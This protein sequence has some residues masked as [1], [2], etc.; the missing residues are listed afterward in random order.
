MPTY[1]YLCKT[2]G[3]RF[4]EFHSIASEPVQACP[5]CGNAVERLI[6]GG[7]GLIFKGS[8][9]YLTDY[10]KSN[11]STAAKTD[12]EP[13]A[14]GSEKSAAGDEAKPSKNKA[15]TGTTASS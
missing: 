13:K 11:S 7:I 2:C 4:E 10:A 14:N 5:Q 1:D 12:G 6:N 8:G 15:S 3:H 9:F